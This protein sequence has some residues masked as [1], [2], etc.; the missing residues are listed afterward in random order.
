[1]RHEL[2]ASGVEVEVPQQVRGQE[3]SEEVVSLAAQE[4]AELLVIGLRRRTAVGKFIMGSHGSA[5]HA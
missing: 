3:P 5:H 1:M 4:N 2:E